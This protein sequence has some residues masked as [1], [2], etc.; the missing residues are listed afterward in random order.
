MQAEPK[1]RHV[2]YSMER[3]AA[4]LVFGAVVLGGLGLVALLI[5]GRQRMRELAIKERISLIDKG[6]VPSPEVDP[7]RFDSFVGLRRTTNSSAARFQSA[8]VLIMGLGLALAL[9]IGFAGGN[10]AVGV[11]VGGGLAIL[12]L[13]AFISGALAVDDPPGSGPL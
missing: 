8:G 2:N 1:G 10:P 3:A 12:G 4:M 5:R 6:L 7:A 13:A 11:G 9:L